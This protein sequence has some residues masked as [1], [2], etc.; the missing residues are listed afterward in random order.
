MG[1]MKTVIATLGFVVA[2]GHKSSDA[3]QQYDSLA[4][5]ARGCTDRPCIDK[6]QAELG[7]YVSNA[8]DLSDDEGRAMKRALDIVARMRSQISEADGALAKL[9]GL[10][11]RMCGCGDATCARSV[12]HEMI[13]LLEQWSKQPDHRL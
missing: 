5:A 3:I 10:R 13:G 2:C 7:H 11:D 6:V 1:K 12:T 4:L 8:H 9:T